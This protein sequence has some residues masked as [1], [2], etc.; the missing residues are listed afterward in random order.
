MTF[1]SAVLPIPGSLSKTR[2]GREHIAE[3]IASTVA[4]TGTSGEPKGYGRTVARELF[5]DVMSY[6]VGTPA[7][8]RI[9]ARNGQT[10]ADNTPEVMLGSSRIPLFP[11]G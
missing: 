8:Y 6:V 4:A 11:L 2:R 1:S 3:L 7:L 10:L 5:P 9:A